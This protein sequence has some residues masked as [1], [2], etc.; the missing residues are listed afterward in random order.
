MSAVRCNSPAM[1][2]CP[3]VAGVRSEWPAQQCRNSAATAQPSSAAT[4]QGPRKQQCLDAQYVTEGHMQS[5]KHK[6][7]EHNVRHYDECAHTFQGAAVTAKGDGST[8]L[9]TLSLHSKGMVCDGVPVAR[10]LCI[11]S[12]TPT[13]ALNPLLCFRRASP[14]ARRSRRLAFFQGRNR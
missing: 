11:G 2:R 7:K 5:A 1:P 14:T 12:G 3:E 4:A 9:R 6:R 10:T 13:P 8:L